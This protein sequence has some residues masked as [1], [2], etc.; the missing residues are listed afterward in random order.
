MS[1]SR[2]ATLL[3]LAALAAAASWGCQR[4]Q[5]E[6]DTTARAPESK[7]YLSKAPEAKAPESK[8]PDNTGINERDRTGALP[9]PMDQSN[10]S[11]DLKITESIREALMK[12]DS[13]SFTAKNVKIITEK[14]I[15]TLRGP[16]ANQAEK[17][18]IAAKARAVAG[19]TKVDNLI[20]V[21]APRTN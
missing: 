7:S 9:T 18:S 12:D 3:A 15:V 8:A 19:V 14:G 17:D 16:V 20:E 13:L 10:E 6:R 21:E 1:D 4:D 5:G 2:K 11:A